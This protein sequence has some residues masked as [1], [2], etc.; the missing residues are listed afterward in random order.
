M[1]CQIPD[2]N[3]WEEGKT[4]FCASHN[5]ERRRSERVKEVKPVKIRKVS[6]KRS[7]E[8]AQ[9]ERLRKQYLSIHQVCEVVGCNKMAIQIHHQKGRENGL[10]LDVNYFMG[11]CAE[12]HTFYTKHSKEA[13]ELGY[14][15]PR[16]QKL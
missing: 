12:H 8:L 6:P 16:N 10:L 2:C 11:I 14:S 15:V 4:G 3:R 9:Y 7:K 1:I 5:L 13:I